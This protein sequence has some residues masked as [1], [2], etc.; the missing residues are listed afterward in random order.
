MV[1][2]AARISHGCPASDLRELGGVARIGA[3]QRRRHADRT[4]GGRDRLHGV[5]QR[6]VGRQVEADGDRRELLLVGDDQRGGGVLEA[7]ERAQRHHRAARDRGDDGR[8]RAR[9]TSWIAPAPRCRTRGRRSSTARPGRS[10]SAA[11]PP[12]SPGTGWPARRWWRSA[13]GRRRRSGCRRWSASRRRGGR[14]FPGRSRPA[15]GSR[16]PAPPR[17]RPA[18]S[19]RSAA[20]G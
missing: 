12:G 19:A 8:A 16:R 2:A 4:L 20:G 9:S 10:G 1:M 5:A 18:A 3:D 15:A 14:R 13:A 7:G 6:G 11:S 17:R